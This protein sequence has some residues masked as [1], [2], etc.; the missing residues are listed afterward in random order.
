MSKDSIKRVTDLFVEGRE[1]VIQDSE[2]DP[3]LLWV[4]KLNSFER[5]E[6]QRDGQAARSRVILAVKESG[7]PEW[8]QHEAQLA[9]LSDDDLRSQIVAT[10]END[11]FLAAHDSMRQDKEWADRM[12]AMGRIPSDAP[13]EELEAVTKLNAEYA[14]ELSNRMELRR[15]SALAEL[16]GL[17]TGSLRE[18]YSESWLST[19]S[20]TA[21]QR[22]F[23]KTQLYFAVRDC[24]ARKVSSAWDHS[25]CDG[26]QVRL[27]SSPTDVRSL[28]DGLLERLMTVAREVQIATNDAR[29]SDALPSSSG[30]SAQ[31]SEPE[32]ST[33]SIPEA[34]S[35]ELVTTS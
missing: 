3:V 13:A 20:F 8:L 12:E 10:Q 30:S 29:F 19:R 7:S 23:A 17:D 34:L 1:V 21:F 11:I 5:E 6:A 15:E 9:S 26:H 33:P 4:N 18:K 2:T 35:P 27:L 32:A 14:T 22:E 24:N 31:P 16:R 28:P 25:P